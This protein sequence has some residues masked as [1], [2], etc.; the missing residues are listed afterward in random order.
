MSERTSIEW[1][2][3]T[4]NPTTGCTQVSPGCD[5]CYAKTMIERFHG[6]GSFA[7]VVRSWDK[8]WLPMRWKKPRKIFVN[9]TS[10]LFHDQVPDAFIVQV[11]TVIARTPQHTYQLLT[12]RHGRMRSLISSPSFRD[13]VLSVAPETAWPL[14]NLW[15]GVSIEDQQRAL[16]RLPALFGTPARVRW[17]SAEPLLAPINLAEAGALGAGGLDWL[18]VGGES[19]PGAR[20]MHTQWARDLRD[21]AVSADIAFHFKQHGSWGPAPWRVEQHPG[22][23]LTDFHARAA[24]TG[25]THTL[26]VWAHL[27]EMGPQ[28]DG[29]PAWSPERAGLDESQ[30]APLRRWGKKRAGRLLD[31]RTWDEYPAGPRTG[32][33]E[34]ARP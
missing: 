29:R 12:K 9:S 6:K 1:T 7:T 25:A 20:P 13:A 19:G 3:T 17:A 30:Q 26:P 34:G 28:S 10:D 14:R 22:E 11:F 5:H 33:V 4:W 15:L 31:G 32:V 21:Q 16:L 18:V 24:A 2:D 27:H 8:L 23:S